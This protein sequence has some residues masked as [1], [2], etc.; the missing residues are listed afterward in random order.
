MPAIEKA[1]FEPGQRIPLVPA[2]NRRI[3]ELL[4]ELRLAEARGTG[5]P[6]VFRAMAE[7]D[8]PPPRYEFDKQRSYF[9]V[10]LPAHSSRVL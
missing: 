7:N 4:K 3:G 9:T 10:I 8:S 2:R 1:H 6:K 5:I